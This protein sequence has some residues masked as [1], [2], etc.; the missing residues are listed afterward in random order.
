[1][2]LPEI[3]EEE[4]EDEGHKLSLTSLLLGR[5]AFFLKKNVCFKKRLTLLRENVVQTNYMTPPI[6]K[7][8]FFFFLQNY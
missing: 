8:H 6:A 1:M 7:W 2:V 4:E 5:Q 3:E